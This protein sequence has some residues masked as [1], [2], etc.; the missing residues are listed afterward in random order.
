MGAI[1]GLEKMRKV[2]G[3]DLIRLPGTAARTDCVRVRDAKY[4]GEA[5]KKV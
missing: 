3:P 5:A 2:I 4:L 1:G